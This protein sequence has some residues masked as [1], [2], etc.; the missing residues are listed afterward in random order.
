M[1][2]AAWIFFGIVF[3]SIL[4]AAYAVGT[5]AGLRSE[6]LLRLPGGSFLRDCLLHPDKLGGRA[7]DRIAVNPVKWAVWLFVGC[8]FGGGGLFS[9]LE[10]KAS[11]F[12]GLW[13]AHVTMYTV[14]YGD[15]SPTRWVMR[16]LGMGVITSGFWSLAILQSALTG[17]ISAIQQERRLRGAFDT[18]ELHDDVHALCVELNDLTARLSALGGALRDKETNPKGGR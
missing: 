2:P 12:D 13:W 16:I 10:T 8:Y 9:V 18:D 6:I 3:A 7:L 11:Y 17:R 14:G 1:A 4:P 5:A 15:L